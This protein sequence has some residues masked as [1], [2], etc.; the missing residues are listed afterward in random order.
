VGWRLD[1]ARGS[2]WCWLWTG[3]FRQGLWR[4]AAWNEQQP[5]HRALD[6]LHSLL[7]F[8]NVLSLL[9]VPSYS[10]LARKD[11]P[12]TGRERGILYLRDFRLSP[13][14]SWELCSSRLLRGEIA[15]NW[16]NCL[17]CRLWVNVFVQYSVQAVTLKWLHCVH[18]SYLMR[19]VSSHLFWNTCS[20]L[21]FVL[22][23]F[24]C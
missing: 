4:S 6:G 18:A 19:S 2:A 12:P 13:R 11:S 5:S 14:S 23:A 15:L 3:V 7:P 17:F 9:F 20:L 8:Y 1:L 16:H 24:F 22:A 10:A 21:K